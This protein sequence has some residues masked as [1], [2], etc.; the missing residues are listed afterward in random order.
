MR[1]KVTR[2]EWIEQTR[3]MLLKKTNMAESRLIYYFEQIALHHERRP[4]LEVKDEKG[5]TVKTIFPHFKI[6][7]DVYIFIEETKTYKEKK[8]M[9]KHTHVRKVQIRSPTILTPKAAID[10]LHTILSCLR[11]VTDNKNI[12]FAYSMLMSKYGDSMQY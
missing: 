1:E 8:E 4:P 3:S 10:A 6:G 9:L 2:K 5:K 12:E 7:E 11:K